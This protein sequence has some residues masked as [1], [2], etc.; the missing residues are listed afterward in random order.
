[1]PIVL[2]KERLQQGLKGRNFDIYFS[3]QFNQLT[4]S[5]A[6]ENR[7]QFNSFSIAETDTWIF[8]GF[9]KPDVTSNSWRFRT[10]S[11]DSSWLWVGEEAKVQDS[12]LLTGSAKVNNSGLHTPQTSISSNFSLNAG[13]YYPIS[14]VAGNNTGP[15]S[16]TVEWSSDGG[17]NWSSDGAGKLFRNP[18]SFDG[19]NLMG[20]QSQQGGGGEPFN[21]GPSGIGDFGEED[22]DIQ[23][24]GA[25]QVVDGILITGANGYARLSIPDY[26]T[27]TS[28]SAT[29]SIWFSLN[30]ALGSQDAIFGT[31]TSTGNGIGA[32]L[33]ANGGANRL[34]FGG[35]HSD[36]ALPEIYY[37]PSN[38]VVGDWYHLVITWTASAASGTRDHALKVYWN[39]SKVI[40]VT[41]TTNNEFLP[42]SLA[43]TLPIGAFVTTAAYYS[44]RSIDVDF[45]ELVSDVALSDQQVST[46]YN[47]GTRGYAISDVT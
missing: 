31:R 16:L 29:F 19:Y 38:L 25:A 26:W 6:S 2:K 30:N 11:D 46:L 28:T 14:I 33:Q 37:F 7:N 44:N 43:A 13:Q 21:P 10:T 17:T 3:D 4:G 8:R 42:T 35:P 40:D 24:I 20:Q 39:G 32:T 15:G 34:R 12:Q 18:Y 1:M 36:S 47:N 45:L 23:L 5:G 41:G 27:S 22:P 9:F